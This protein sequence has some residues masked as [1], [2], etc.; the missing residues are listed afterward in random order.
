[1]VLLVIT[2][3]SK[4]HSRPA[5]ASWI[6]NQKQWS[7]HLEQVCRQSSHH[8]RR[9][10]WC[11]PG[12][13]FWSWRLPENSE[14]PARPSLCFFFYFLGNKQKARACT[15]G[16]REKKRGFFLRKG[17]P[18]ECAMRKMVE[19]L[20]A[21][22]KW[23]WDSSSLV[24]IVILQRQYG[25]GHGLGAPISANIGP[26]PSCR[27]QLGKRI[28]NFFFLKKGIIYREHKKM[29]INLMQ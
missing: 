1:M 25:Y 5:P 28:N 23:R 26:W 11:F 9:A 3:H 13:P 22:G 7:F 29:I 17:N 4:T 6:R 24:N 19:K 20:V 12:K 10:N 27:I 15:L 21:T 8:N 16:G 14:F 18:W 2:W